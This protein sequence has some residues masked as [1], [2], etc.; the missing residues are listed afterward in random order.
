MHTVKLYRIALEQHNFQLALKL[1][2]KS[3]IESTQVWNETFKKR[4]ELAKKG[5]FDP[6][7]PDNV[8]SQP[9]QTTTQPA[10]TPI[11][12]PVQTSPDNGSTVQENAP[13]NGNGGPQ[14]VLQF[15]SSKQPEQSPDQKIHEAKKSVKK[16]NMM[17]SIKNWLGK[18][19]NSKFEERLSRAESILDR[20]KG[21]EE[22]ENDSM[23]SLDERMAKI[24][25]EIQAN[26]G[27]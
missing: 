23:Q 25:A 14:K 3:A 12:L 20:A 27:L 18:L 21:L 19:N 2:K 10:E 11:A 15:D 6:A 16:Q 8:P 9:P 24:E 17:T 1:A 22:S 26:L 5:E 13:V 4:I 7:K